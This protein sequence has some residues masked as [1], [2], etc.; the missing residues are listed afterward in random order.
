MHYVHS[1]I[2]IVAGGQDSR[3]IT[4]SVVLVSRKYAFVVVIRS[5]KTAL[6]T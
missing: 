5:V 3:E 2:Q 6:V 4:T 1:T